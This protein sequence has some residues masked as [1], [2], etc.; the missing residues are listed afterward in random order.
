MN[1]RANPAGLY[2]IITN[3][4]QT[5][6]R[7]FTLLDDFHHVQK[8]HYLAPLLDRIKQGDYIIAMTPSYFQA[9]RSPDGFRF[10]EHRQGGGLLRVDDITVQGPVVSVLSSG[11]TLFSEA[12]CHDMPGAE[13][14]VE[15]N[16]NDA[17]A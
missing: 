1:N 11:M 3:G 12:D 15:T 9:M 17:V 7:Y 5:L 4:T 10:Y 6:W 8:P 13:E 2:P 16:P 14:E